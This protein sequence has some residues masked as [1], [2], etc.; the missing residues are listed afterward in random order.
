M[1]AGSVEVLAAADGVVVSIAD[2]HYD[3]C[4]IEGFAISCDGHPMVGNHVILE[5]EGGLRSLYWHLMKHS[6][7]VQIGDEVRCGDVLGLVGSSGY[8]SSPH[9]HFGVERPDGERVDPYAGP[10][11]QE[12]TLWADQGH[13]EGLPGAGCTSR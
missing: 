10:Y 8:S 7:T 6:V 9:L 11:S 5:H 4:H 1:D 3:R 2:G 13:A 12:E